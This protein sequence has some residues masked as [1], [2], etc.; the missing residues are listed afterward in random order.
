MSTSQCVLYL[1]Q[2][3]GHSLATPQTGSFLLKLY[4]GQVHCKLCSDTVTEL[5]NN[6]SRGNKSSVNSLHAG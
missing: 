6:T 3:F 5:L 2:L 1:F 4:K